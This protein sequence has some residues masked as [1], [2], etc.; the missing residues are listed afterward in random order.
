MSDNE[1]DETSS[2]EYFTPKKEIRPVLNAKQKF[3]ERIQNLHSKVM[4]MPEFLENK[5]ILESNEPID[6]I[7]S[8]SAKEL[9]D[10]YYCKSCGIKERC[11]CDNYTPIK[12][13][14]F[15]PNPLFQE[16][17]LADEFQLWMENK[18]NI[19]EPS[20]EHTFKST[21]LAFNLYPE[22]HQP[23]GTAGMTWAQLANALTPERLLFEER[24]ESSDVEILDNEYDTV[25]YSTPYY[26]HVEQEEIEEH[27]EI[28]EQIVEQV[29]DD[30]ENLQIKL[31]N[32]DQNYNLLIMERECL[33]NQLQACEDKI[34][35]I[36]TEQQQIA[37]LLEDKSN[38][39]NEL[40]A[41]LDEFSQAIQILL[42]ASEF[43]DIED[44]ITSYSTKGKTPDDIKSEIILDAKLHKKRMLLGETN[45]NPTP[46][47]E[48]GL[49]RL[50][51]S[52]ISDS[53]H[54]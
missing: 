15:T 3:I 4:Q 39:A 43:Y 34:E 48:D 32:L 46:K 53:Y 22:Q 30:V 54:L 18:G 27:E 23:T 29:E 14:S 47:N 40:L 37:D 42:N 16:G 12:M 49:P 7:T 8:K 36:Q 41:S 26:E 11:D 52:Y 28:E 2:D 33:I 10:E 24:S 51:D 6:E 1:W 19:F 38:V 5:N 44:L 31:A 21:S 9:L 35:E 20:F 17:K 50:H 25:V 13:P 45:L